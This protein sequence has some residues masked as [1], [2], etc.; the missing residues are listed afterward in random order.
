MPIIPRYHARGGPSAGGL[1]YAGA[2]SPPD[3][4]DW[5]TLARTAEA[6][7]SV[8]A[9]LSK[10]PAAASSPEA[11]PR[12]ADPDQGRGGAIGGALP[13]QVGEVRWGRPPQLTDEA[14]LA[15]DPQ[16]GL[17]SSVKAEQAGPELQRIAW[18]PSWNPPVENTN[19]GTSYL[20]GSPPQAEVSAET[21]NLLV[22]L[23]ARP[24][25]GERL[26]VDPSTGRLSRWVKSEATQLKAGP[27]KLEP[28]SDL[29]VQRFKERQLGAAE[30]IFGRVSPEEARML[31]ELRKG[32]EG[33]TTASHPAKRELAAALWRDDP[34]VQAFLTMVSEAEGAEYDSLSGDLP[35]RPNKFSDY[36]HHPGWGRLSTSSGRYQLLKDT[37][38]GFASQL[39]LTDFG[40]ETQDLTATQI[41]L[42]KGIL[43]RLRAG[44][45][46]GAM[47]KASVIWASL[48]K[49]PG[50]PN[51]VASQT[52]YQKYEVSEARYR[53]LLD[54]ARARRPEPDVRASRPAPPPPPP[55]PPSILERWRP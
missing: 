22:L 8:L 54:Q 21:R 44:D 35:G 48:S 14:D 30:G 20:W 36:G 16:R 29:E 25:K 34:N 12:P 49:G 11:R 39:G 32:Q 15:A 3:G 9:A 7:N 24:Q 47:E 19:Y 37:Y 2:Y 41:L 51:R 17:V 53:A 5:R 42:D 10:R 31:R 13:S 55:M 38:E 33:K 27:G 4:S 52:H 1:N 46:A 28:V 23:A 18:Q 6:A 45:F 40:P 26:V 43:D 50:Q